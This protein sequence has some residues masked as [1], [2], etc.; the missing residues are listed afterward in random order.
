VGSFAAANT[1]NAATITNDQSYLVLGHNNGKLKANYLSSLEK[2]AGITSRFQREW[3]VVNT[4]FAD[5]FTLRVKYDSSTAITLSHLRL[6]VDDDGNFSN[7]TVYGT[8]DGLTFS[9]GSI[10]V[11]GISTSMIPLGSTKYITIGSTSTST[12][13]PVNLLSFD[14][15]LQDGF[16]ELSWETASEI[17]NDHFVVE[18]SDDGVNW[19][20]FAKVKGAGNSN[21]TLLYFQADV[22]NFSGVR[23]YRLTQVD[24]DGTQEIFKIV[25]VSKSSN[26]PFTVMPNPMV[27]E[28]IV[29]YSANSNGNYRFKILSETGQELY[30]AIAAT[31]EG[32]N[33]FKF[34]TSW[35]ASGTYIFSIENESGFR[36]SQKVVK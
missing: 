19:T 34:N 18:R 5:N 2:P 22:A 10:I 30:R 7:A 27:D 8:S 6:L 29:Q 9:H 33:S 32:E 4:N 20:S 12:T 15:V 16:V 26:L 13:L 14:A 35:L 24:F 1:S 17:N 21:S 28:V 11:S 31:V 23:Y 36:T 3:K 25:S